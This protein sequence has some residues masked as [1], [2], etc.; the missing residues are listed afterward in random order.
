[1]KLHTQTPGAEIK[2]LDFCD[3]HF[4]SSALITTQIK[5]LVQ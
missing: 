1:M 2:P 4:P 5:P 3:R